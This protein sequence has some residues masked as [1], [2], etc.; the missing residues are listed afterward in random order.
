MGRIKTMI[1][2]LFRVGYTVQ[3]VRLLLRRHGWSLQVPVGC[4]NSELSAELRRS[5][6]MCCTSMIVRRG[7][8]SRAPRNR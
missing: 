8:T 4:Q 7:A 3:G 6:T 1:G 5:R 2:R